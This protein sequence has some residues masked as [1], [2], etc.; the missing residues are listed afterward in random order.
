[1]RIGI[2]GLGVVS[3]IGVGL[4]DYYFSLRHGIGE[5]R[6]VTFGGISTRAGVVTSRLCG[7]GRNKVYRF[8]MTACKEALADAGLDKGMI[9]PSRTGVVAGTIC[10]TSGDIIAAL[11]TYSEKPAMPDR[12]A[13]SNYRHSSITDFLCRRFGIHG[14]R[15]TVS[16]TCSTGVLLITRGMDLIKSGSCDA[17]VVVG[18]D[19]INELSVVPMSTFRI[20][21]P[22]GI[23]PFDRHRKGTAVGE[24]C[25]VLILET[26]DAAMKRG[27]TVHAE[28]LGSAVTN[29]AFDNFSPSD[30][31]DALIQAMTYAI[32][33]SGIKPRDIGYVNAHGTGTPKNDRIETQAI[34]RVFGEHAYN[35]KVNST[36]S[37]TGHTVAA[38][39]VLEVIAGLMAFKES[40]VHPTR[41][42]SEQDED[43]DLD[44]VTEGAV[45]IDTN[46]FLCN[47]IG[48]GGGNASLV[49]GK[50]NTDVSQ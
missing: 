14:E 5:F 3:P 16:N 15:S 35:L 23:R 42:Y 50:G 20:L 7:A 28:L 29:D 2:T 17:V 36:K 8:A 22:E 25:G 13:L 24:G 41:N 10:G 47:S 30:G 37:F 33:K 21:D 45:K 49:L 40:I 4:K 46:Y 31:A 1:M 12:V 26:L 19:V 27:A 43:C 38:A 48:F 9:N 18:V 39:G 34:K 44:Y 32:Q 6:Y 11:E